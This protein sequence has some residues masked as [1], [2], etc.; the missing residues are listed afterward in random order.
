MT[1]TSFM[2]QRRYLVA[3]VVAMFCGATAVYSY[4][5]I[6]IAQPIAP[7]SAAPEID[8]HLYGDANTPIKN[9][10]IK[11]VYVVP[12]NK[13]D[14]VKSFAWPEIAQGAFREISSFHA[15]QFRGKSSLRVEVRE[16]PLILLR[17]NA[18]Y[19]T[20][21]TN[22][23]NPEALRRI[24]KEVMA[25]V[26][27]QDG[28][29]L[30][31][32]F[33]RLEKEAYTIVGFVYEGVGLSGRI[34]ADEGAHEISSPVSHFLVNRYYFE[35]GS[36]ATIYHE[37]LHTLG[38]PDGYDPQTGRSFSPDVMGAGREENIARTYISGETLKKMG[39]TP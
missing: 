3:T 29:L 15:V 34:G 23:G 36:L 31:R 30:D 14:A 39:V 17:E 37:L 24:S 32:R 13:K 28:D 27:A 19:D 5:Q 2:R 21:D 10:V 25:R 12:R 16:D 22:G 18:Y 20:D 6:A 11:L 1:G 26:F 9:V 35:H 4:Y 38:V 8:P 7:V 33:S